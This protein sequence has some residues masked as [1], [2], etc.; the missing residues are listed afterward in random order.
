[1]W[2][3][4]SYIR[5]HLYLVFCTK[6]CFPQ[7]NPANSP[8]W[9]CFR[10]IA[11]IILWLQRVICI[12]YPAG[13]DLSLRGQ[14]WTAETWVFRKGED[15]SFALRSI[16]STALDLGFRFRAKLK[17]YV[18]YLENAVITAVPGG[19]LSTCQI[20]CSFTWRMLSWLKS[21]NRIR[22]AL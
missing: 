2:H 17:R 20:L 7:V 8:R 6:P 15:H 11:H 4:T 13:E 12:V 1:L 9:C 19:N 14:R 18:F 10:P 3:N 22:T 5:Q 16:F 21:W